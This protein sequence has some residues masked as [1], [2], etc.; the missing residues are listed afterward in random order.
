MGAL[1]TGDVVTAGAIEVVSAAVL[2]AGVGEGVKFNI[3]DATNPNRHDYP[4]TPWVD[5]STPILPIPY[6][7]V[8]PVPP[9]YGPPSQPGRSDTLSGGL[10]QVPAAQSCPGGGPD[11]GPGNNPFGIPEVLWPFY[12]GLTNNCPGGAG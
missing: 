11:S 10:P 1:I 8:P 4:Q 12:P 2:S 7:A 6:L 3:L 9:V 5:P